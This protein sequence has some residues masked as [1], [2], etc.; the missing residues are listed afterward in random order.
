LMP[1]PRLISYLIPNFW[2][3]TMF[4]KSPFHCPSCENQRG[5]AVATI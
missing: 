3:E 4:T 5:P 2:K 1:S